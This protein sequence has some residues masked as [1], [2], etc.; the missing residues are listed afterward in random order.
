MDWSLLIIDE[1]CIHQSRDR[2][3]VPLPLLCFRS[4]IDYEMVVGLGKSK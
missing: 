3:G 1:V 2:F 4:I